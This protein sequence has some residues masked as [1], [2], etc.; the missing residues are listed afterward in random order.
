MGSL[1][2]VNTA[3]SSAV[4]IPEVWSDYYVDLLENNLVAAKLFYDFSGEVSQ[5]GDIIHIPLNNT[6]QTAASYTEGQRLTDKLQADTESEKTI[7]VNTYKVNPFVIS[8]KLDKQSK[9]REKAMKYKKAAYA[10][11][12]ALDT[13]ILAL[14]SGFTTQAVNSGGSTLTNLDITEAWTRLNANDVPFSERF[15]IMNPWCVKD[16]FDLSGNY[17]T[18]LDF[19]N[20]KP[21]TNG[22]VPRSLLGSPVYISNN[23]PQTAAGSPA[24]PLMTNIYAHKEAIGFATQ[25][26]DQVQETYDMDIQGTL[27]NVRSLYG[28]SLL[29]GAKGVKVMRQSSAA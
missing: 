6:A 13:A 1:V 20:D 23:I 8:D 2:A 27:C 14:S 5:W 21:L 28:A 10:V 26:K 3:I 18:S 16:L 4:D 12:K 11:A 25:M 15:W 22:Q 19:A 9:Y 7:T 24:Q 29:D 17:F